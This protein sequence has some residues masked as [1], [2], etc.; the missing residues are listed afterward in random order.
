[1]ILKRRSA[2]PWSSRR[3]LRVA[4]T[5][6]EALAGLSNDPNCAFDL[7][8]AFFFI[9]RLTHSAHATIGRLPVARTVAKSRSVVLFCAGKNKSAFLVSMQP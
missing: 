5:I 4:K 7:D 2:S 1:M 6:G 8:L 9:S 3:S